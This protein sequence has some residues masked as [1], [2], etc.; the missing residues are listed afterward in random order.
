[1]LWDLWDLSFPTSSQAGAHAVK[2]Q[3]LTPGNL[4]DPGIELMSLVFPAF[5]WQADSLH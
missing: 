5:F 2:V 1:M 3:G 4:P